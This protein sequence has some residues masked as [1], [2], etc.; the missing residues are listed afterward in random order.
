M[1][2]TIANVVA[3][4]MVF[5]S[6][7]QLRV[8]AESLSF[9]GRVH[10][11]VERS[12]PR[13]EIA[14]AETAQRRTCFTC[15]GQALPAV[16]FAAARKHGFHI[17]RDNLLRQLD[18][19]EA[20]L[21]R[22]Q[23]QYA[24]G[25]GTG[26][27]VD[28]AG[29]ALWGLEAGERVANDITDPVVEYLLG[30][31]RDS[32]DWRCSGNRPPSEKSHF[33]TT[34]LALRAIENF[35]RS[36]HQPKSDEAK[37]S[38]AKWFETAE[39]N[40]TED[41]VFQLLSLPYIG[42]DENLDERTEKLTQDLIAQ[43][44]P[45]GGWAQL[46]DLESDAYATATVLYALAEAGTAATEDSYQRG[47]EYLLRTQ[48]D[49]GSWHVASR[50]KPFQ[51]Y[52]ETGYPHGKDQFIST[53]AACWATLVLL[54]V[55]PEQPAAAIETLAGTKPLEWP[56]SD[57]S[58]RLMTGAHKFV[59]SRIAVANEK[60]HEFEIDD[61][62]RTSLRSELQT[63]LGVVEKR[64]PP[65][66]EQYGDQAN[67]AL[68]AE[69][70]RF[71][72]FQ[73][74]W[75]VFANV[76]GEGLWVQQKESAVGRCVV[77]PDADQSPEQLLGLT[78]GLGPKEQIARRLAA[79]GFDLI[80]P[81]IIS[82]EKMQ[83]DDE[84]ILRAEMT[85]REWI[86]RQAFHMGRHVIGYD[87]QRVFAAIDCFANQH[88]DN[89]Q[90]GIVGYGEGGLIALHA[91][92]IDDRIDSTLVSG[93][94]DSSDAAW[95]EPIYRNV[96]QRSK[97]LGNAEV[98]SLITPR[99]LLIEHSEFPTVTR[100]KG[101]IVTPPTDRVQ[102]AFKRIRETASEQRPQL[103]LG[104]NDRPATRWS[105]KAFT[106]FLDRFGAEET[107]TEIDGLVDRRA[108]AALRMAQ[109]QKRC[110]DQAEQHVQS[111]VRQSE[112]IRDDF[113]LYKVHPEWKHRPWSTNKTHDVN[114]D[115]VFV[116]ATKEL[117]E[118][119][120]TEAM[121]RFDA[122]LMQPNARTR[123]VA[124]TDKWTAYDVVLDVHESLFAWG[125]LLIPKDLEPGERRP[126]VVC[127]H[128]RNG[129]PR[130]TIDSGKNAYNDYAAKLAE[131][132]FITLAP[133]NLYRGED[134]YRWLDRKANAIGCT[135]F[136]FIIPSHDQM[137]RWLDSLPFVDGDRIAFYGLSYGGESAVRIPTALPKYCLSICSG[138]FN[139]WTRKVA[140]TDQPF[141]FMRSTEWEMP[142]WNLG[143]TFDYAEMTYLMYP[144]PFMVER[145]HHDGVG[146]DHWVAHEFAKVRWLYAQFGKSDRVGIEFF[147]GGHSIHGEGTFEFLHKHLN[148]PPPR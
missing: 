117:R 29:W 21:K 69:G 55:L 140:S 111:L 115:D 80:I 26:G 79:S 68:V 130:D 95:S 137:L 20:H 118:R 54:N 56:E 132:G 143:H 16:V 148:W 89:K 9:S 135:L 36:S 87:L 33:A 60:R 38:A 34:Y 27:Q 94:F 12:L 129:I 42:L 123:K 90:I 106:A 49:D 39:P 112:H 102:S 59:E 99:G 65:Q 5:T 47:L 104:D 73:V 91:A 109:R 131:R 88:E 126:V 121:G 103:I 13:L 51:T 7:C 81:T 32:G 18:H 98:A 92:A 67:P 53:T 134:K 2:R 107:A 97:R 141:S 136:S 78:D 1:S 8:A 19:T 15:H 96:W 110:T 119:F 62:Q 145:G 31:Q 6:H 86:Y 74:R 122:P 72:V 114:A 93:Y 108:D 61:S 144:R 138:D 120:T 75:P 41:R 125:T 52:F 100:H 11:A 45:D 71:R 57:L 4:L 40:D 83:T 10:D 24:D 44:R 124:E 37:A 64:L 146:R 25:R 128:G 76:F 14:S 116:K 127:Q 63:V 77:V 48:L 66:L 70:D 3:I 105:D 101:D 58:G 82:R 22:S 50:S 46:A 28:T 113:F 43:Q 23:Q 84:R 133:H 85:D 30:K 147:L 139:Q 142:Y 17:D 35:G